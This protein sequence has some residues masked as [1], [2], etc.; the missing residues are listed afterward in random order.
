MRAHFDPLTSFPQRNKS[1]DEW[2]NAVQAQIHLAKYTLETAKILYRDIFCFFLKDEE[3]VSKTINGRSVDLDKFP[4][5]KVCQLAR[6]MESSGGTARHIKQVVGDP[7]ATHINL[8]CHQCTELPSG[9]YKKRKL[10]VKQKEVQNKKIWNRHKQVI[11]R[12]VLTLDWHTRTKID[13]TSVGI[14]LTLKGS[15]AKQRSFNVRH[16]ISLAIIQ[17]FV[18]RRFNKKYAYKHRKSKVHQL[19][20]WTIHAYDSVTEEDS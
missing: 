17:A 2:Y 14:L 6:K 11:S 18:S 3:F 7:Q 10:P 9:K 8:M 12:R 19:K 13:V 4:S 20:A 5:S 1:V 16:A 15:S